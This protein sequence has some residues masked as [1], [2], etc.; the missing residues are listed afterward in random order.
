MK[1]PQPEFSRPLTVARIAAK[2]SHERL[3]ADAKECKA[4]AKRFGV[5]AV[6][7]LRGLLL[8]KPWRGG[9]V[10]VT[11]DVECD[12][13]QVS[14]VSLE[15]FRSTVRF[16][17]ERYFLQRHVLAGGEDEVDP[18]ENGEIDLGEVMAETIALELDPYPRAEGEAFA[19][20][21]DEPGPV[22]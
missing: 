22:N 11:G 9:G 3:E 16:A 4:L 20:S 1:L 7:G 5:P 21:D 8:A 10:K 15:A 17:V 18:I 13:E 19:G 2:G 14:V 6:H 12:L